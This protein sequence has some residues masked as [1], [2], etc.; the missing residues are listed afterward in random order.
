MQQNSDNSNNPEDSYESLVSWSN[1]ISVYQ[2]HLAFFSRST[3][4]ELSPS[5]KICFI[6]FSK[7]SLKMMKNAFFS[8]KK[9]FSFLI[10]LKFYLEFLAYA[11]KQFDKKANVDFKIYGATT[12]E[13]NTCSPTS[14]EVKAIRQCN[15]VS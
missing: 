4:V 7:N 9:L 13:T 5:K 10:F 3:K 11:G 14:K 12:W 1:T 8:S 6:Y 2:I 15:L